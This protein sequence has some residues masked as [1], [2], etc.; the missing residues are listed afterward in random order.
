MTECLP[1]WNIFTTIFQGESLSQTYNP[2]YLLP[3]EKNVKSS[4][5]HQSRSK[6]IL[7][8]CLHQISWKVFLNHVPTLS[9]LFQTFEHFPF[10]PSPTPTQCLIPL[11]FSSPFIRVQFLSPTEENQTDRGH[12]CA[13]MHGQACMYARVCV[14]GGLY[15]LHT[16]TV[17]LDSGW[18]WN[19]LK[20]IL[21]F[22]ATEAEIVGLG[23]AWALGF[24]E[25]PMGNSNVQ[26]RFRTTVVEHGVFFNSFSFPRPIYAEY[27]GSLTGL[28]IN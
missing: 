2:H 17:I 21:I 18:S 1:T 15:E 28:K 27:F 24:W 7:T 4:T 6:E 9:S 25:V 8:S 26:P 16:C 3:A 22:K 23:Y 11:F 5:I 14:W 19:L 20:N 12:V 10:P 13:H